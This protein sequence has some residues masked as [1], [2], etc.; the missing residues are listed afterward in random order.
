MEIGVFFLLLAGVYGLGAT[1]ASPASNLGYGCMY[2]RHALSI[3]ACNSAPC[4]KTRVVR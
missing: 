1:E 3:N 2:V 4:Q